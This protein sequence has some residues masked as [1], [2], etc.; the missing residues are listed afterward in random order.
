MT[1][2]AHS[3]NEGVNAV[4]GLLMLGGIT[5]GIALALHAWT[6]SWW[7]LLAFPAAIAAVVAITVKTPSGHKGKAGVA[8]TLGACALLGVLFPAVSGS[9]AAPG[10]EA[11]GDANVNIASLSA[12]SVW[13]GYTTADKQRL[14]N[15]VDSYGWDEAG[16]SFIAGYGTRTPGGATGADVWAEFRPLVE[17]YC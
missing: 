16:R 17:A 12:A 1:T 15:D 6:D 11:Q 14:C 3:H 9:T 10:T 7:S 4:V 2:N 13:G 8:A 5:L